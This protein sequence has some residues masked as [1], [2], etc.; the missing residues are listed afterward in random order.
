MG[1]GLHIVQDFL[2][3]NNHLH[4]DKYSMKEITECIGD[5]GC[6]NATIFS[7]LDLTSGFWQM[8]L[9]EESQP[10]TA[11]KH[12]KSLQSLLGVCNY[13]STFIDS[14]AMKVGPLYDILKGKPDKGTFSMNDIQMKSFLEIKKCIEDAEKLYLINTFKPIYIECDA[15]MVGCGSVFY[16][17]EIVENG[18]IQRNIIHY[19]SRKWTLNE[20]LHHTSL[21]R[22]AMAILIRVKQH[23]LYLSS[24][25]EAILKTDLKSLITILSCYNNPESTRMATSTV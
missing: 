13:M 4:I 23:L 15:S 3:L 14:Y 20:S 2:E 11:F 10:L 12:K 18:K 6:A 25:T 9:D 19:G 21:E 5:I 17:E 24:S 16:Q 22:E 8:K 7:K 1:Q